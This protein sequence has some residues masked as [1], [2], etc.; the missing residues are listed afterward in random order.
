MEMRGRCQYCNKEK[1]QMRWKHYIVCEELHKKFG[2]QV[3]NVQRTLGKDAM[4]NYMRTDGKLLLRFLLNPT[5]SKLG[6]CK[7]D[8]KAENLQK[9]RQTGDQ[10]IYR[11]HNQLKVDY[12]PLPPP[13]SRF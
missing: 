7:M 4:W 9:L 5:N 1:S 11:I 13:K 12:K 2:D 6:I 8:K 10:F 3:S